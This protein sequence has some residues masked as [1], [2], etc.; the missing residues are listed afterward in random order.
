MA[1]EQSVLALLPSGAAEV[2]VV[3]LLIVLG[4]ELVRTV[5]LLSFVLVMYRSQGKRTGRYPTL[6]QAA[7]ALRQLLN[8]SRL[9]PR[10]ANF[11][12]SKE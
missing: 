1:A 5:L 6:G 8:S 7:D 9:L 10:L 3:G 12:K 2:G 4:W 11:T